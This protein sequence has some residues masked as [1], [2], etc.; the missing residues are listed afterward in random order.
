MTSGI[1]LMVLIG[2]DTGEAYKT[3]TAQS[4]DAPVQ[5]SRE[6]ARI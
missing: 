3:G 2:V 6:H 4:E 5:R 1:F